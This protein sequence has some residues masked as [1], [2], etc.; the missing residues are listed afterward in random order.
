MPRHITLPTNHPRF[1]QRIEIRRHDLLRMLR[2]KRHIRIPEVIR[3]DDDDVGLRESGEQRA[4]SEEKNE[5]SHGSAET[6]VF[7]GTS[8]EW[9]DSAAKSPM[10]DSSTLLSRCALGIPPFIAS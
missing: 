7:G 9:R 2:M 3:D 1:G 6:S 8:Q 10:E 4:K 5:E